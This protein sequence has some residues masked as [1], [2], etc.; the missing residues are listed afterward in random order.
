MITLHGGGASWVCTVASPVVVPEKAVD[1]ISGRVSVG[2][3]LPRFFKGIQRLHDRLSLVNYPGIGA[4]ASEMKEKLQG[5]LD[6]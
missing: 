3:V 4:F 1:R 5:R 2:K 6:A